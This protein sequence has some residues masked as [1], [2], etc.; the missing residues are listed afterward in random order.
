MNTGKRPSDQPDENAKRIRMAHQ[1]NQQAPSKVLHL[2]NLPTNTTE[3]E[4]SSMVW[5]FG[6]VEHVVLMTQKQQA[7]VQCDNAGTAAAVVSNIGEVPVR[8]SIVRIQ[9]SSHQQLQVRQTPL[10]PDQ[11]SIP[12][13]VLLVK[14]AN[15]IHS[16]DIN[17]MVKIFR[18]QPAFGNIQRIAT[19]SKN[20]QFNALVELDTVDAAIAAHNGLN[21][22]NIY[23]GCCT[24]LLEFSNRQRVDIKENSPSHW[25][26]VK[27]P[28]G[29]QGISTDHRSR[30]NNIG[31]HAMPNMLPPPQHLNMGGFGQRMPH[32]RGLGGF[33]GG[34]LP[35]HTSL[36]PPQ[37]LAP[38]MGIPPPGAAGAM[39]GGPGSVILVDNLATK[40]VTPD[41]LATLFGHFADVIRVKILFKKQSSALVQLRDPMRTP[42][43]VEALNGM[44]LRGQDLRLR[45]SRHPDVKMPQESAEGAHLTRDYS[46]SP[47]HRFKNRGGRNS[48][49]ICNPC[50]MLHI[51]NLSVDV[52]MEEIDAVFGQI[53]TVVKSKKMQGNAMALVEMSSTTDA[54]EALVQLH[55]TTLPSSG[56]RPIRVSFSRSRI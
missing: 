35:N 41:V 8:G 48:S 22:Q 6:R 26:F 37:V 12:C 20:G 16:I 47:H 25:D 40:G 10:Q 23:T 27:D 49:N 2:R 19:F 5:P 30:G 39:E 45:I 33:G 18:S 11:Q 52:D 31:H 28:S 29:F 50:P 46:D 3:H 24:A 43:T 56:T 17:V 54:I 34:S 44:T 51:S 4:V 38:P 55:N 7:L 9:F 53:G 15:Q 32:P 13:K 36:P 42:A 1:A 21:G 14:V